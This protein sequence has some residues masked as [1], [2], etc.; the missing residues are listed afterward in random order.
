MSAR[1]ELSRSQLEG[2]GPVG[3]DTRQS[4]PAAEQTR[5]AEHPTVRSAPVDQPPT[6][7]TVRVPAAAGPPRE[8]AR[9]E[10]EDP[11][12]DLARISWWVTVLICA[13]LVLILV[14][15]GY[16]GYAAVTLA[17]GIAAGINLT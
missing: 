5:P 15:Q 8:S 7:E 13:A 1:D 17:V 16:F 4:Q 9:A 6:K 14:L 10:D 3:P 11:T 12:V 2:T